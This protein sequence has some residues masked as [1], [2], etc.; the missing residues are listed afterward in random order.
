MHPS[1]PSFI[2]LRALSAYSLLEGALTIKKLAGLAKKS[3][4]PALGLA[5]HSNLF[6]ALEFSETLAKEGVQPIIGCTLAVR[7]DAAEEGARRQNDT[8]EHLALYAMDEAGYGAL[9][10]LTSSAFLASV[11]PEKP[12]VSFAEVAANSARLIALTGGADGVLDGLIRDGREEQAR[13]RYDRLREAFGDRLYV[14]LQRYVAEAPLSGRALH[15]ENVLIGWAYETGVPLVATNET[16]FAAPE[17]Y[18]AHDALLC[19]AGGNVVS[20]DGRRRLT[21]QHAFKSPREMARLFADLPEAL[22]CTV[23]VAR[24]CC[25]RATV[26]D[27]ILPRYSDDEDEALSREAAEGLRR[28]LEK[29]G[30]APGHEEKEYQE[31][32]EFELGVIRRMRYSGYFLIV[33]DFIRWAKGRSIPVGPGRGSGAGSVVA[34]ALTITDLD[35]IRFGL[36]FER[37][38]NPERVSMPDFDIDFCPERREEVIRYVQE[39]YGREQVAQ[40]IT[41]GTLQARAVLRDVGRVLQMRYGQVDSLCR[42]VPF[43]PTNPVTL[44]QAIE[45]EA[46]LQAEREKDPLVRQLLD[47]GVK[48]EGLYRHPS[49]HA[50]GIVIG[51]RPLQELVP[52]FRD[53]RSDMP[54]T[55][56]NMKWVEKAGL[57]KFD[58]LGLK[59]LTVIELA[60]KILAEEG[61]EI[62][63]SAL[64]IDDPA[65]Y[66][67][68]AQGETVGVFQFESAG[69]RDALRRVEPDR[70]ED[71][72]ALVALYRPGPMDNIPTYGLR[73]HGKE[74]PDYLHPRL[75]PILKETFGVII[76]Q[77]QVMQIAQE[78]SGYS[79]GEADLLRRAMGKKIREEMAVQRERFVKGAVER[80][81]ERGQANTIFDLVAKFADYGFNKSHAAAYALVAYQTAWLKANYPLAFYA[82]AMTLDMGNTDRLAEF[83]RDAGARDIKI[84]P[85]DVNR[86]DATFC[87]REG[88]ITYA[89]AALRNVGRSAV[90][91]IVAARGGKSYRSLD[92]LASRIDPRQVNKRAFESLA[93]SGAF[94]TLG[95]DRA[96]AFEAAETVL[97][98]AGREREARDQG[99][100]SLFGGM[101]ESASRGL[102]LPDVD[103]WTPAERLNREYQSVGFFLSGHPLEGYDAILKRLELRSY[104]EFRQQALRGASAG[105]LAAVVISRQEKRGR[106]GSRYAIIGLS[107]PT[108]QYEVFVFSDL[109][110][111]YGRYFEVGQMVIVR[112]E[113]DARMG[114]LR[115]S[116]V[117]CEPLSEQADRLGQSLRVML[118]GIDALERVSRRL[119]PNGQGRVS[120]VVRLPRPSREVEVQ[121]PGRWRTGPLI[122][123]AIK[124]VPGVRAVEEV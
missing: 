105:R 67:L 42:L 71:L 60:R 74:E 53:P 39:R 8:R 29:L 30:V 109:L 98:H 5:D 49:T 22:A 20:Q 28:R 115:L 13:E 100:S 55:Q 91:H 107:D 7:F 46:E 103:P 61:V 85:P 21:P 83:F 69:M 96:T 118:D 36:L 119:E 50:A 110:A 111:A 117:S 14:E 16:Y 65:T 73:K 94:D 31:R 40:I 15:A 23:E 104:A 95:I 84:A 89:L 124:T 106:K 81:I 68:L 56:F 112:V 75:E 93:A 113:A 47:I 120:F 82:A 80:G 32:L 86:S 26:R 12:A 102:P 9:M 63:V 101:A 35:P 88:G 66:R 123:S 34:W 4:M 62:D 6:G 79:L 44:A 108:G 18:D 41:F 3:R 70:F 122:A 43:N 17:D 97:A 24:R 52:L 116:L 11:D 1:E 92:D 25:Y 51:D 87:V 38:L 77:E 37:F 99:Q 10:R 121:L 2:H 33:S 19:I 76:Y 72:I 78:L 58:F 45:T 59:T 48:L 27:P 64:P 57:V 114:E 90:E 54:V